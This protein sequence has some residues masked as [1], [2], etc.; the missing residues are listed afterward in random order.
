MSALTVE[1]SGAIRG[2]GHVYRMRF[3]NGLVDV[4]IGD[5]ESVRYVVGVQ[6]KFDCLPLF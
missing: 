4:E 3:F 2:D 5:E 1:V 6:P